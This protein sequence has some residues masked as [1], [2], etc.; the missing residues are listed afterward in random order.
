MLRAGPRAVGGSSEEGRFA[1]ERARASISTTRR[2][3][4]Q[5]YTTV[6][7]VASGVHVA[8]EEL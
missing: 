8:G 1:G 5:G 7:V 4:A 3:W 2:T 6:P